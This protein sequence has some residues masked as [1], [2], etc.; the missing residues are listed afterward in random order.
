[1]D[2]QIEK[3][4][5]MFHPT[6]PLDSAYYSKCYQTLFRNLELKEP[7]EPWFS[8]VLGVAIR[9]KL[10]GSPVVVADLAK[11]RK[12]RH[13]GVGSGSGKHGKLKPWG[14]TFTHDEY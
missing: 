10:L 8:E 9:D 13:L 5:S 1:M 3:F 2:G 6:L 4:H 14:I 12:L 11:D 7:F